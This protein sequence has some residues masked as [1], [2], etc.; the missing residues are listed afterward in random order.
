MGRI[1]RVCSLQFFA[2]PEKLWA[3]VKFF[4]K[5]LRPAR[6]CA[7]EAQELWQISQDFSN[8]MT[9]LSPRNYSK[10]L[11]MKLCFGAAPCIMDDTASRFDNIGFFKPWMQEAIPPYHFI[12]NSTEPTLT[13]DNCHLALPVVWPIFTG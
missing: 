10:K 2:L 7:N 6:S 13:W 8:S 12:T 3:D 5:I 9:H 4:I 1:S 11:I